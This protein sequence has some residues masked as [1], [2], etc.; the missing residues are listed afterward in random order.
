MNQRC[1]YVANGE[2]E[3]HQIRAFLEA[4][5]ISSTFR[6]E[7]LRNTHGLTV[8]G[9]GRVEILVEE[10]DEDRARELLASADA[11]ELRLTDDADPS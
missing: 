7:S 2:L 11:G 10:D 9:L 3:A 6:G 8:D 5:G 1:V 4:E